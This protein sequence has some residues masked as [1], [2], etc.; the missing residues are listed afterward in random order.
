MGRCGGAEWWRGW[1]GLITLAHSLVENIHNIHIHI[2]YTTYIH[3][4][5]EGEGE[6]VGEDEGG[7]C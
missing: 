6:E 1:G 3:I 2:L 7:K 5:R 4:L